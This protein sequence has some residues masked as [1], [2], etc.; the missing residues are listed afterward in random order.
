[1]LPPKWLKLALGAG[2]YSDGL[3]LNASSPLPLALLLCIIIIEL[4]R[5]AAIGDDTLGPIS[6]STI[7]LAAVMC[8]DCACCAGRKMRAVTDTG[9]SVFHC[10]SSVTRLCERL[11][12]ASPLFKRYWFCCGWSCGVGPST[13]TTQRESLVLTHWRGRCPQTSDANEPCGDR[14]WNEL[15]VSDAYGLA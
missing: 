1:M 14:L 12:G 5:F 3:G 15:R 11:I 7:P 13:R 2:R 9:L 4:E 6:D 8:G 10:S